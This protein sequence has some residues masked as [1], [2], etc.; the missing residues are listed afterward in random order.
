MNNS[1]CYGSANLKFT[2][3]IITMMREVSRTLPVSDFLVPELQCRGK[4][5]T[6]HKGSSGEYKTPRIKALSFIWSPTDHCQGDSMN[7]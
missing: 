3:G 4:T 6:G 7:G 2:L 1:T 5:V